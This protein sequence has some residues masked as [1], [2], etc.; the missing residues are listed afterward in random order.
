MKKLLTL[1]LSLA[2]I[3]FVFTGCG[4]N[5]DNTSTQDNSATEN[6]TENTNNTNNGN[7]TDNNDSIGDDVG[8][9]ID[10]A[11]DVVDDAAHD[12]SDALTGGYDTYDDAYSYFMGQLP[13]NSD[14]YE[15]RNSDKDLQN[16]SAGN[17]GY[18]FEL[19]DTTKDTDSKV[20]D[21]Y[22]DSQT[23]KVYKANGDTD[24]GNVSEFDFSELK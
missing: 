21:F 20:G 9:I 8:D 15:V 4:S 13:G 18:H 1:G 11:G 22:V 5:N 23:G 24:S 7:S 6:S 12:V 19:H 10:D 3:S 14:R 16:Y 2:L 17:T